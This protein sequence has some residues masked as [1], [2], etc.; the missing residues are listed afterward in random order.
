MTDLI[1]YYRNSRFEDFEVTPPFIAPAW[2]ESTGSLIVTGDPS[3]NSCVWRINN[4]FI[5]S[6]TFKPEV[7]DPGMGGIQYWQNHLKLYHVYADQRHLIELG[8]YK[9]GSMNDDVITWIVNRCISGPSRLELWQQG[10]VEDP[11]A[12]T[13]IGRTNV[14]FGVELVDGTKL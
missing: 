8:E 10:S 4:G 6:V 9:K 13:L 2:E 1:R 11:I 3:V 5:A 12:A 7:L 14:L